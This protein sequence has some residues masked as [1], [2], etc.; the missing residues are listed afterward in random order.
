MVHQDL[1]YLFDT[2][3]VSCQG[4][5]EWIDLQEFD[6]TVY[7]KPLDIEQ[8]E[9]TI[10]T[11]CGPSSNGKCRKE[12]FPDVV[13]EL[14]RRHVMEEK[15]KWD[16]RA[17]DVEDVGR[18]SIKSALF[19]FKAVHGNRFS[20]AYWRKFLEGRVNPD[21]DVCFDEAKLF[22]CN[23]PEFA[24][25]N[26]D[27][28]YLEQ[29]KAI[30]ERVQQKDYENH[31]ELQKLQED[32]AY[33][34]AKERERQAVSLKIKNRADHLL[35]RM[36]EIGMQA[37]LE[38]DLMEGMEFEGRP[39]EKVTATEL[40]NALKEKYE[41][42]REKLLQQMLRIHVGEGMW[43]TLTE[44]EQ[45]EKLFQ[46]KL[47]EE[48]LRKEGK[49]DTM[50]IHLPGSRVAL[51]FHL[52]SLVGE[53]GTELEKRLVEEERKVHESGLSKDEVRNE[54][55]KKLDQKEMEHSSTEAVLVDI[56][57]R[58]TYE[59]EVLMNKLQGISGF[60]T[61][62]P[63]ERE[64]ILFCLVQA[65]LRGTQE[66]AFASCGICV[67][68]SERVQP[69]KDARFDKDPKKQSNLSTY[70]IQHHKNKRA[71]DG[72]TVPPK[73]FPLK[74]KLGRVDLVLQLVQE[75]ERRFSLER[76]ALLTMMNSKDCLM[77]RMS[78]RKLNQDERKGQLTVLMAQWQGWRAKPSS[79]KLQLLSQNRRCL[80]EAIALKY[81]SL[82]EEKL[83]E[84]NGNV[85]DG[86]AG[87]TLLTSLQIKQ[88]QVCQNLLNVG[89]MTKN[90]LDGLRK[91]QVQAIT[92]E[93]FDNV[94]VVVFGIIETSDEEEELLRALNDK[95]DTLRDK[96]L[97]DALMKQY[98][99]AEWDKLSE[100]E[101]QNRLAKLK[102]LEKKLRHEGK[103]DELAKLL[104]DAAQDSDL[105][106]KML[107]ENRQKY[108]DQLNERLR[109][110]QRRIE[111]GEDPDSIESEMEEHSETSS[112]NILRDLDKRFE[113][114]RDALLRKLREEN[115]RK[116]RERERQAELA[117]LRL[118]ARKA[119]REANF[120]SA[121][122][123]LGLAERNKAA[124]EDRLK[125]DRERQEQL[126]KE[127]LAARRRRKSTKAE[128]E[129]NE[130]EPSA[131]DI[132]GW[133]DFVLKELARKQEIERNLFVDM[134]QEK[135]SEDLKQEAREMTS[136]DLNER[137]N[138]L[139]A[140]RDELDFALKSDQEEHV[141]ILEM[142]MAVKFISKGAIL[143]GTSGKDPTADDV[144]VALMADLQQL[145]DDETRLVVDQLPTMEQVQLVSL[146]NQFV[147]ERQFGKVENVAKLI[148]S[149][150][151]STS[152]NEMV[153]A[154]DKKY[155]ALLD[156][157]ALEALK[158]QMS[159][160]EWA[161]L[162]EQERQAKL[163]KMRLEQ[164]RL[165]KEGKLD[166]AA[167]LLGD[168]FKADANLKKLMGE[169]KKKY[170]E[171]LQERLRQRRERIA[172]GEPVDDL[173]IDALP[174][175]ETEEQTA[176]A[177]TILEDLQKRYDDEKEALLARL[178][179]TDSQF[180][181][182]R[183]RQ[184]ELARLR[185]E[186]RKAELEEKFG[187][188]AM[189][190]GLAERNSAALKER[191]QNDRSRQ[192]QLAKERLERLRQK[193]LSASKVETEVV[194]E[195]SEINNAVMKHLEKRHALEQEDLV[196]YLKLEN[197]SHLDA[198][199]VMTM[200]DRQTRL[201]QL[202]ELININDDYND[203]MNEMAALKSM[204]RKTTLNSINQEKRISPDDVVVSV[205]ADL[206]QIQDEES[207]AV[208]KSLSQ[209]SSEDL[210]ELQ[211]H[212]EKLCSERK[213]PNLVF[214]LTMAEATKK[215]DAND[216]IDALE[217]KYDAL[218][219]KLI[220]DALEKQMGDLQWAAL[221]EQERQRQ[222]MKI[223]LEQRKLK[224]EG[225]QDE[226]TRIM[227]DLLK[228]DTNIQ[229]L[230]GSSK[231][232]Q[233][234]RLKEKLDQRKKRREQGMSYL[235][236]AKLEEDE[237]KEFEEEVANTSSGNI[238][239]DLEKNFESE[240]EAL[241]GMLKG[242][243]SRL[244]NERQRQLAL[245]RLR[246]EAK[247]AQAEE[248][249]DAAA[250]VLGMA[251]SQQ[252]SLSAKLASD[253]LRQEQLARERLQARKNKRLAAAATS[254]EQID[255]S[256]SNTDDVLVLQ[257]NVLSEME[258]KHTSE[259]ELLIR[260]IQKSASSELGKKASEMTSDE[261][262]TKLFELKEFRNQWRESNDNPDEQVEIF[263][264]AVAFKIEELKGEL[265]DEDVEVKLLADLQDSQDKEA[266]LMMKDLAD[267]NAQTLKQLVKI[268]QLAR[269][270]K[271][272]DNVAVALLGVKMLASADEAEDELVDALKE[273]YDALKEKIF[274]EAL[275]A[276]F[277]D[278]W[279]D[280]SEK[281]KQEHLAKMKANEE[282]N[283]G[284]EETQR[285]LDS[286]DLPGMEKLVGKTRAKQERKLKDRM[287]KRK[288]AK[289][290]GKSMDEIEAEE[291]KEDENEEN[292]MVK[293]SEAL[294]KLQDQFESEK[295][296][297][298]ERL[299][300]NDTK[301]MN[302]R[303]RQL[304]LALLRR[305]KMRIKREEKYDGAALVLNLA[306]QNKAKLEESYET[307]RAR[308]EQL[309]RERIEAMKKKR[310]E[311]KSEKDKLAEEEKTDQNEDLVAVEQMQREGTVAIH[312]TVLNEMEKKHA[313]EQETLLAM[314]G[315]IET[316][317]L[318]A[319]L[320]MSDDDRQE[321]LS[322]I[323]IS[324][325]KS[326]E[327]SRRFL[328]SQ[329][330][331]HT[332]NEEEKE[333]FNTTVGDGR[334]AHQKILKDGL[335]LAL[336]GKMKALP[337][338]TSQGK[339]KDDAT[340]LLMADLQEKQTQENNA[341]I[342]ALTQSDREIAERLKLEQRKSRRAGW[343]DNTALVVFGD[344]TT[345]GKSDSKTQENEL[346]EEEQKL[347][348]E[349][350]EQLAELEKEIEEEKQKQLSSMSEDEIASFMEELQRQENAKR[351]AIQDQLSRQKEIALQRLAEK[352]RKRDDKLY[353]NDLASAM[354]VNAHKR[355][356]M[357]R[358]KTMALQGAQKDSLEERLRRR[359][360]DR[361]RRQEEAAEKER[362]EM[363]A[364]KKKQEEE[365]E[366]ARKENEE[367]E[368]D[369]R[370]PTAS[371]D[372]TAQATPTDK[373]PEVKKKKP[374]PPLPGGG[375]RREKTVVEQAAEITDNQKQKMINML[376]REQTS[377]AVKI[378]KEKTRQEELVRQL[379]EKR[380][381]KMDARE[382]EAAAVLGL[383]ERQKTI[384][385]DRKKGERDRQIGQIRERVNRIKYERTM[386]MKDPTVSRSKKSFA[387]MAQEQP[388]SLTEDEKMQRIAKEMEKKFKE[389]GVQSVTTELTQEEE[390]E[391]KKE[392]EDEDLKDASQ[393]RGKLDAKTKAQ[394]LKER[395]KAKKLRRTSNMPPSAG[396]EASGN[397]DG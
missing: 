7:S 303:E 289:A 60:T 194:K 154:L 235:D 128:E 76:E 145:Q 86:I 134:M 270:S 42:L 125:N 78:A 207:E 83:L 126:A 137:L 226:A 314:V 16:F 280:M 209:K 198:S 219:D 351:S 81:E 232:E 159:D 52:F 73:L 5:I 183:E 136:D 308:Q 105:L 176:D 28:D 68:L 106:N 84:K 93:W 287:E 259:R 217:T 322:L 69:Q 25:A 123:V 39:K 129:Q 248:K 312:D 334:T 370:E 116:N 271:W 315:D 139:K 33:L 87:I 64:N 339:L 323:S 284:D 236:I 36:D 214:V 169:N 13:R 293:G 383:G 109:N 114:E 158:K 241:L 354:I 305:E 359:R 338:D 32:D 301:E 147:E 367:E 2:L 57:N 285:D 56:N 384:V 294:K 227:N 193:R 348:Q 263:Q 200:T 244:D 221:N 150:G 21:E 329:P 94:A 160:A 75:S 246:R 107:G 148:F 54:F 264:E 178:H 282:L 177:K 127:R 377:L 82:K 300:N 61:L 216:L 350:E 347:Q 97:M 299:M 43:Q 276:K 140:K 296:A 245:A 67:G 117:R 164:K 346:K 307:E 242:T 204:N 62:N 58:Y 332:M 15:V 386:T 144:I 149:Y 146:R 184:A 395:Q 297:I 29:E 156:K 364:E 390:E 372:D 373:A 345:S 180:M 113:D 90:E 281:E 171:L 187:A 337:T 115:D 252:A 190:L 254:E 50:A 162:S 121:A 381:R 233:E 71:H 47:K 360:E 268:Q 65:R 208:L 266:E 396:G 388:D 325:N 8:L 9:A 104:S 96:L 222:L 335:A 152:D 311:K 192:E 101:R 89:T 132:T 228:Q 195:G 290:E 340:V 142:A 119:G 48:K 237:D 202:K 324:R 163:I 375:M 295:N 211:E 238:L 225:K 239:Q 10:N 306:K 80:E 353:E 341:L 205:L 186:Q 394:I 231:A 172:K 201:Q 155:D 382:E 110:R 283:T 249:Y 304:A 362:L 336:A 272:S 376:M 262:K 223:K 356:E 355:T 102:L 4:Y 19:L 206:Q 229:S 20:Q 189:V 379:R 88:D 342:Q 120:D 258:K 153:K 247:K 196:E 363:E 108:L 218:K 352:R 185:R 51:Q 174:E 286:I 170:D 224:Q 371:T 91:E 175:E 191:L 391:I 95:Y 35:N 173:D 215:T 349:A 141:S 85:E 79:E 18:I 92:E 122:L 99:Q 167:R 344:R 181:N 98:S 30:A 310:N 251:K 366:Q 220:L 309:A 257:E 3:D 330:P 291:R 55:L 369:K 168:G 374:M 124:L 302:E 27:E 131:D 49:L 267:K 31:S 333:V 46:L 316:N 74:S 318:D 40:L 393:S 210:I 255:E 319:G 26:T 320:N 328:N 321:K 34:A 6:E 41:V 361:K 151:G 100:Q 253:R 279:D 37:L 275:K 133:Q 327:Q 45:H 103:F 385:E 59:R 77:H 240:K 161:K 387:N 256:A 326:K 111:A 368:E 24:S 243:D 138:K 17:L 212:D 343:M 12:Y 274:L 213:F 188:A 199:L 392:K 292:D 22:L 397:E 260:L 157:L 269:Q 273:K 234:R 53:S 23:V 313:N 182:E 70:R 165:L 277:G 130:I 261:R 44:H 135:E 288:R 63:F 1:D 265:E 298:L 331:E 166:E 72:P 14:E 112:G 118:E 380:R 357:M 278:A 66:S 197:N 317:A 11:V 358:E 203:A 38:D 250:L 378:G 230:L 143:K 365:A 179:G 389:G